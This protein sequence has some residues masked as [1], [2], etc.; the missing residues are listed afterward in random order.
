LYE[1]YDVYSLAQVILALLSKDLDEKTKKHLNDELKPYLLE[2]PS[3]RGT[4]DDLEKL[5]DFKNKKFING[6]YGPVDDF[7]EKYID[8]KLQI[9]LENRM[10]GFP[11]SDFM[12]LFIQHFN[13]PK[14]PDV[15]EFLNHK[16]SEKTRIDPNYM[17]KYVLFPP[18]QFNRESVAFRL[19]LDCI[20]GFKPDENIRLFYVTRGGYARAFSLIKSLMYDK[21][22]KPRDYWNILMPIK[23][24]TL[25]QRYWFGFKSEIEAVE[26]IEKIQMNKN[27]TLCYIVYGLREN[28]GQWRI[29]YRFP[30]DP[31]FFNTTYNIK[32]RI[33]HSDIFTEKEFGHVKEIV[34][35]DI[36]R[37]NN[38]YGQ[39]NI[40]ND[41]QMKISFHTPGALAYLKESKTAYVYSNE[42]P[43]EMMKRIKNE[44][45]EEE[46]KKKAEKEK[47]EQKKKED[48]EKKQEDKKKK[49]KEKEKLKEEEKKNQEQFKGDK[50][51]V[52]PPI[53]IN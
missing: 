6:F 16:E 32:A 18:N 23:D 33:Q 36:E 30:K 20:E 37:L 26:E 34:D 5:F 28:P 42:T 52:D 38:Q 21:D 53:T 24:L 27:V 29:M 1:K 11:F 12:Q 8:E 13:Q 17:T 4:L 41:E 51:P 35:R 25:D 3:K 50:V 48:D 45:K 46:K 7:W 40:P 14:H 22:S 39:K 31:N 19:L 2:D 44:Q 9:N 49:K 47:D 15:Q 10:E 43:K